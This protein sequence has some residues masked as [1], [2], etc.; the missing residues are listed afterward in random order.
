M[1]VGLQMNFAIQFTLFLAVQNNQI[2]SIFESLKCS[3][4]GDVRVDRLV[5]TSAA[6]IHTAFGQSFFNLALG[7]DA[8]NL[9]RFL[10]L[11]EGF[12]LMQYH[13]CDELAQGKRFAA[14]IFVGWPGHLPV[15]HER[16][17]LAQG[18]G[19]DGEDRHIGVRHNE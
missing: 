9:P 4:D 15:R 12:D 13:A 6:G 19:A 16:F 18:S 17:A 10:S 1:A 8:D 11:F 7:E 3:S 14:I 5:Q 2:Q